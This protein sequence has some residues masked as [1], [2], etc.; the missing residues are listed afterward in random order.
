MNSIF[1]KLKQKKALMNIDENPI[2]NI[3]NKIEE[4]NGKKIYYTKI[5]YHLVNFRNN[6]KKQ[7][8]KLEFKKFNS[9]DKYSFNLFPIEGKNKFLGIRYGYDRLEKPFLH[10]IGKN[11]NYAIKKL[12]YIE[13]IFKTGS[14]KCYLLSL[15][16]L[17]RKRQKEDTKYYKYSLKHLKKME[18]KVYKF[19]NKKTTKWRNFR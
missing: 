6:C 7:R 18:R 10:K 5:F 4:K 1:R 9:K 15:R 2:K 14:I 13:F 19:Y 3:F 8:L 17:L 16:T 12:Y 11:R